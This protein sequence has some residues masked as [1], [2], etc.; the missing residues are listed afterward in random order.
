MGVSIASDGS[1]YPF[2]L[3]IVQRTN[4]DLE[5]TILWPTL[6]N[7]LTKMKGT[8]N[9]DVLQFEEYEAVRGKDEVEIP[10]FCIHVGDG[11]S[12]S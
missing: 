7:S 8:V 3:T 6:G 1:T 11:D 9:S 5:G 2:V 10:M 12:F 4:D